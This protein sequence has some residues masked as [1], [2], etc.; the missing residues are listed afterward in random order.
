MVE[1]QPW[2]AAARGVTILPAV[3]CEA[4]VAPCRGVDPCS[5]VDPCDAALPGCCGRCCSGGVNMEALGVF[6]ALASVN[7]TERSAESCCGVVFSFACCGGC[8][9]PLGVNSMGCGA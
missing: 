3:P 1:V 6:G 2:E 8:C 5:G 7:S 9:A 4:G